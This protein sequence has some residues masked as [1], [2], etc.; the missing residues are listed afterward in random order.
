M[1]IR[2]TLLFGS[3]LRAESPQ[4][5]AIVREL[6]IR[7]SG[8]SASSPENGGEH[9]NPTVSGIGGFCE[10]N[11]QYVPSVAMPSRPRTRPWHYRLS[12]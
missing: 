11:T 2:S 8:Q 4:E 5:S 6:E 9:T 10:R 12:S 7:P 1:T 3:P